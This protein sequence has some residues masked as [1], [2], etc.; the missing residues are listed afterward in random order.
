MTK[1]TAVNSFLQPTTPGPNRLDGATTTV[2]MVPSM[3]GAEPSRALSEGPPIV[4]VLQP[5]RHT[6]PAQLTFERAT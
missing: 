2:R 3:V 1:G 6:P 5:S 4:I